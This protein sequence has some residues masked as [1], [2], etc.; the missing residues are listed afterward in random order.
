LRTITKANGYKYDIGAVE[1]ERKQIQIND[2]YDFLL[3]LEETPDTDVLYLREKKYLLW[4][5][6]DQNDEIVGDVTAD[7]NSEIAYYNRNI[8]ADVS[9]ALNVDITRGGFAQNT[10]IIPGTHDLYVSDECILFGTWCRIKCVTD[11]NM[12]DQFKNR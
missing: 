5:F 10:E 2:R 7:N 11:I 1:I 9:M 6:S 4:F 8:I 12:A 3:L